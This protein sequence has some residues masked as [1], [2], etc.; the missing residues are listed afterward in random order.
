MPRPAHGR[1]WGL[2]RRTRS[3]AVA[4]HHALALAALYTGELPRA[5]AAATNQLEVAASADDDVNAQGACMIAALASAYGGDRRAALGWAERSIGFA[6]RSGAPS[7]RA[8]A[9]YC[10]G[11]VLGTADTERAAALFE[12]AITI[13]ETVDNLFVMGVAEVSLTTLRA[14]AG[15]PGAALRTFDQLIRRWVGRNDWTHQWTTLQNVAPLLTRSGSPAEAAV[16]VGALTANG[17]ARPL[18]GDTADRISHLEGE[19]ADQ[20]GAAAFQRHR[21]RGAALSPR[22]LVSFV[23]SLTGRGD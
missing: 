9:A 16:L 7:T 23:L 18:F 8:W 5:L 17:A 6:D 2:R 22:E 15:D 11:E 1:R 10:L 3:R 19:L 13:G 20:L 12:Q 21:A 14:A 4:A